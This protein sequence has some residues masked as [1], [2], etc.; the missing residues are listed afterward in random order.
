MANSLGIELEGKVV[1]IR[2]EALKP[3]FQ[4]DEKRRFLVTGGF[5]SSSF[6]HGTALLG[7]FLFDGE[8][9]RMDGYDVECLADDQSH[10]EE[11]KA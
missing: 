5:G 2:A 1:M 11:V 6:T 4:D 10:G 3:E 9:A 8:K 7:T